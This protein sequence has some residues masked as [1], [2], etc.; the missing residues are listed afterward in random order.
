MLQYQLISK[1][2][3]VWKENNKIEPKALVED[4][5]YDLEINDSRNILSRCRLKLSNFCHKLY[6]T[7]LHM[8]DTFYLSRFLFSSICLKKLCFQLSQNVTW[9]YEITPVLDKWGKINSSYL[10]RSWRPILFIVFF[11]T[12]LDRKHSGKASLKASLKSFNTFISE[13]SP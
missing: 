1:K 9:T 11:K 12:V 8:L 3:I 2:K 13:E 5:S 7:L 10:L 4:T 6:I